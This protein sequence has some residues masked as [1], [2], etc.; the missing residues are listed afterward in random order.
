MIYNRK[1]QFV[2]QFVLVSLCYGIDQSPMDLRELSQSERWTCNRPI[3][4]LCEFIV[5]KKMATCRFY[6]NALQSEIV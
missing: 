2:L 6:E 5:T 1:I 4:G 3:V